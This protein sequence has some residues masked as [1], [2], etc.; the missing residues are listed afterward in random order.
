MRTP[1][2]VYDPFGRDTAWIT[3][4]VIEE[5]VGA[6]MRGPDAAMYCLQKWTQ[7][8]A[9][10]INQFMELVS[11]NPELDRLQE[12]L[13]D[14]LGID[15]LIGKPKTK[16]YHI[17]Q[18][19]IAIELAR[20]PDEKAKL[21]KELREYQGWTAKPA[22]KGL[23]VSVTTNHVGSEAIANKAPRDAERIVMSVFAGVGG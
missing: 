9:I 14:E 6:R 21:Y 3:Q 10:K 17:R 23:S 7:G 19:E 5:Y 1:F 13:I 20:T 22:E 12:E 2:Y 11:N 8:D 18:L 15:A 16:E 4:E